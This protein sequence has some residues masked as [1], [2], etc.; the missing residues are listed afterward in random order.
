MRRG[1][2]KYRCQ[3]CEI[4]KPLC[5]C[6]FIPRIALETRVVILMHMAERVLTTNTARLASKALPNSEIRIHGQKDAPLSVEGVV[7]AGRTSL[8][9]Y[10]SPD[11]IELTPELAASLEGP[12]T[13]IVPDGSW[14]QTRKMIA[15]EARLAD[16]PRVKLPPGPPSVYRLRQQPNPESLCTFE[17][18]ARAIGLLE[19]RDAEAQLETLLKV[20][21]E[22]TLWSRGMLPESA[23][24]TA[25][26]PRAA[27]E[28]ARAKGS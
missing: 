27:F 22:R 6:A 5:F 18:I 16:V 17:G 25:G 14:R 13:L 8:L 4:R 23:C 15:R 9:L 26:I 1:L 19:S 28:E 21:V 24:T 7:D 12:V 10:P 2:S 11:A 20:M 3:G